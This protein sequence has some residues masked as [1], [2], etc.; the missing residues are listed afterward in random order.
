MGGS[1]TAGWEA[2]MEYHEGTVELKEIFRMFRKW[3]WLIL[4]IT[5]LAG[6]T[7]A[8]ISYFILQ[9]QYELTTT[10]LVNKKPTADQLV[11]ND[12]MANEALVTTY[13]EIIK[14]RSIAQQV[15]DTLHLPMSVDQLDSKINVTSVDKSQ[16]MSISV[17]DHNPA[18]AASIANTVAEV[19]RAKI[20]SLMNVENVQI[21]DQALVLPNLQPVKPKPLLNT[22]IAVVVG[23][24]VGA[25]LAVL[26]EY[27]DTSIRTEDDVRRYLEV[28][29]LA[30]I[31]H[32]GGET[33][34]QGPA[35]VP[36]AKVDPD[37]PR[38]AV[39]ETAAAKGG[40]G[41][42]AKG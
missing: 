28:P 37:P 27:L 17:T 32:I 9:P 13:A 31:S 30:V 23:F 40:T 29:V 7:S 38:L 18:L 14:S 35:L 42:V 4:T 1:T 15:I 22:G 25:G 33:A 5:I 21:V 10:L 26:L 19:F 24:M 11:Y 3:A 2:H 6:L 41:P 16:V 34:E 8:G 12:I 39:S 36:A 20:V